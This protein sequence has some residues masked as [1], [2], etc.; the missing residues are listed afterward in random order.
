M[1]AGTV[2]GQGVATTKHK[3]L[4]GWRLL[5]VQ[6]LDRAEAPDGEPILAI[7]Q[8]GAGI[9][10]RVLLSNDGAGARQLVNA[11]TSPVRLDGI[12][13]LRLMREQRCAYC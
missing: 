10:Q 1:Q 7:D 4:E 9:G 5:V 6:P 11:R 8:L 13:N 2:I 12:G 3:S